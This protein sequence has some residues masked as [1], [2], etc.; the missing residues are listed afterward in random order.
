MADYTSKESWPTLAKNICNVGC[1][2][3]CRL[4][5]VWRL[6]SVS[7][8]MDVYVNKFMMATP[9]DK[10]IYLP[11]QSKNPFTNHSMESVINALL[12]Y[13]FDK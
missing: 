12:E 6:G 11:Q 9:I 13:F 2:V 7:K 4:Y 8:W 10:V 5:I 1:D 3:F